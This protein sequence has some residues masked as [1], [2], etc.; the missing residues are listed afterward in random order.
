MKLLARFF[1]F[2]YVNCIIGMY[3]SF[4]S[5]NLF[6]RTYWS[7]HGRGRPLTNLAFSGV[8]SQDTTTFDRIHR[9]DR[10]RFRLILKLSSVNPAVDRLQAQ[11]RRSPFANNH[12]K[13]SPPLP[14]RLI[15]RSFLVAHARMEK[16]ARKIQ[17]WSRFFNIL[18]I[19]LS[20][21]SFKNP[22]NFFHQPQTAATFRPR[23]QKT[24][25][26]LLAYVRCKR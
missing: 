2:L 24:P 18:S 23:S 16:T 25:P 22:V 17:N 7:L 6:F 1:F 13:N 11:S 26:A 14:S 19:L 9:C 4:K 5:L 8:Q 15:I 10:R 21:F 20:L 12:K 3:L